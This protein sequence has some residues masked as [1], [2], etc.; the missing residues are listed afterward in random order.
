[1]KWNIITHNLRGLN[2]PESITRE[3]GF[4]TALTSRADFIMIQ[5]HKLRG[6]SN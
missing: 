6:E 3:M 1:M 5:E 4:L 2:D